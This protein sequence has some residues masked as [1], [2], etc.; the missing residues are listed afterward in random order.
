MQRNILKLLKS[1]ADRNNI[2][3]IS[4]G[5][6][7]DFE[8]AIAHGATHVRVGTR[9]FWKKT[10]IL[11]HSKDFILTKSC[12]WLNRLQKFYHSHQ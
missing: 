9:R 1:I 10:W 2:K 12:S 7:G 6:S 8:Q 5:M 3:I 4:M 11:N